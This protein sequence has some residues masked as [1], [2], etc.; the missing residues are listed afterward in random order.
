SATAELKPLKGSGV[1]GTV[2]FTQKGSKVLVVA[3]VK[4]LSPG[5][6]GFHVHEKG[7]CSAPDGTSAG[8]HFNPHGKKHG[9]PHDA[10]RHGGDLGNLNA[11]ASGNAKL[12]LEVDGLSIGSGPANI[13][14]RSVIVHADPDDY[15]TQPTG[16]SGGRLACGVIVAAGGSRSGY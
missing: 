8:G 10:E 15:K 16:N 2:N 12:T 3:S 9:G 1:T 13:I 14:G 7:D 4:G 5:L 11:D 6:H